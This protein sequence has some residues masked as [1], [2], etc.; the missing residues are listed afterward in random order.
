[1]AL[2]RNG[3]RFRSGSQDYLY[4]L[5][6]TSLEIFIQDWTISSQGWVFRNELLE[7]RDVD[8]L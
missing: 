3:F 2:L 6:S 8:A 5:Q 4:I 7:Q 1:M